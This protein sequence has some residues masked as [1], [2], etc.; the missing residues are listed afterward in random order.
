MD[1]IYV[2]DIVNTHGLKGEIRIL[3][4]FKFKDTVFLQGRKCYIGKEY[5]VEVIDTYR[6]HKDYD[7]ITFD[8]KKHIDDV[9]IYKNE[10]LYVNRNDIEYDGYLDEDLIGLDVYCESEHIGHVDSILKTNAHEILLVKNGSKHMIPNVSEFIKFV[11]LDKNIL[12]INYMKGL[13]NED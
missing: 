13:L 2:G 3:S 10:S 7:M 9:I 11:D 1:Y 6:T 4:D 8:N 5:K 12:E